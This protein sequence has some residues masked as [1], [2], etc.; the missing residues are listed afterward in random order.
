V[1]EDLNELESQAKVT[2]PTGNNITLPQRDNKRVTAENDK[3]AFGSDY[4]LV[5]FSLS[6]HA[7]PYFLA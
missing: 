6:N 5:V 2:L 4:A 3:N 7:D 1:Q